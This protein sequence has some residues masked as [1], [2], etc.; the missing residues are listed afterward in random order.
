M[1]LRTPSIPL[2]PRGGYARHQYSAYPVWEWDV[3]VF[4]FVLPAW[5]NAAIFALLLAITLLVPGRKIRLNRCRC[6]YD[7][8]GNQSGQCPEC[9]RVVVRIALDPKNV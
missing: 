1:H 6:G 8:M 3:R 4:R 9:G 5:V 2:V 7:L